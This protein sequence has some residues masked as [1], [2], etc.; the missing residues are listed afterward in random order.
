MWSEKHKSGKVNFVERYKHPYTGKW[1]RASVLMEKDTPRI[2]KEAQ[3]Y[4]DEK[5]SKILTSLTTTDAYLLDVMNEWWEHHQKSLKSTSV[6]SLDFRIREL[7]NLIGPEVMIAKITTKYLQSIIDKIPGSYD[8]RKRARQLLK[9]TF[10]YAIALEYVS[11][12]PVIST[13]LA[14]P[15]KTI[16]DF[17]DVAQ[18]FLE[19]DELKRL[20]DEMYRRKGSIKMAYLAEFMS[21]N[22]C[23]IG[24][25]LAIQP[26]NIK[27][28]IIEIHG[29]LDYTSNGY[30]NAIKTTPKTN[31][32][33]RE[34]LIT[35]REK[36]IIQDILKINALEK[37]TNP[38]YKDMGY[39][40]ISRNGVP[41]QDNALNTS[42]RAANKRLEK[43]IQKEL[44]SHIFRHTLVSRLAENKVPLKTIMDRVGHADSKTTQ[45]IYTHV[46]KSMKNEV[47]DI[48]NRL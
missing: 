15:V 33:W 5:I 30:R 28:D 23:R 37:N 42:I 32:S 26:D 48:L 14:K 44:T 20:L 11:I 9:Q 17:E 1:C 47:V 18:K 40:F 3:K 21:L 45:Q 36:E 35:K 13:Q 24:E 34:T 22:G 16:K 31:S 10:D 6:R 12:N 27:N 38:N 25:A 41:I 4:L 8:K 39:I 7:R 43:P 19:K 2:R 46:T 29:T